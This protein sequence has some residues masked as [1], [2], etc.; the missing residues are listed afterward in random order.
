MYRL[1]R[2]TWV[3]PSV[4]VGFVLLKFNF[5]A[6]CFVDLC[7]SFFMLNIVL[8]VLLI[9]DIVVSVLLIL[10]IVLSVLLILDIVLSVLLIL[11]IVLSVLLILITHWHPQSFL[12]Y[13]IKNT[14]FIYLQKVV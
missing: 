8:S 3:F 11:D 6:L 14:I 9:L 1:F 2:I 5:F 4:F 13:I 7:L 10:D 12:M